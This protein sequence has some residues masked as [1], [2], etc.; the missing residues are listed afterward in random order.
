MESSE[1]DDPSMFAFRRFDLDPEGLPLPL[2]LPLLAM[3]LLRVRR[4]PMLCLDAGAS[5]EAT[6]M[7]LG[8]FSDG[9]VEDDALDV[10]SLSLSSSS[11]LP[12]LLPLPP[13]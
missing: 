6:F 3:L 13:A 10:L 8:F 1:D 5:F 4:L 7:D 12:L 2:P 11:S 9:E